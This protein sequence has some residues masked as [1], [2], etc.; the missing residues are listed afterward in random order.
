[1]SDEKSASDHARWRHEQERAVAER[2]HDVEAEFGS[3]ANEAAITVGNH[4]IRTLV[5]VNGGAAVAMLAFIGHVSGINSGKFSTK[6]PELTAPLRW[7]VWGVALA[8]A[9]AGLAYCTNYC[10]A[11]S[12]AKKE[13]SYKHPF[14]QN[15]IVSKRWIRIAVAFQCFALLTSIGSLVMFLCGM[16]EIRTVMGS[17]T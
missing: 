10:I 17:L 8:T 2:A 12:S 16:T 5:L 4:A 3:K 15:T 6:L 13:R 7:F 14:I 11:F 1:M 9:C